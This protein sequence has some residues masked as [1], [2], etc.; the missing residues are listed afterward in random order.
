MIYKNV[1]L[2]CDKKANFLLKKASCEDFFQTKFWLDSYYF[3][4]SQC[5]ISEPYDNPFWENS[6]DGRERNIVLP[7]LPRWLHA[8]RTSDAL[9][10]CKL[11]QIP[12]VLVLSLK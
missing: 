7:K 3:C 1:V 2:K 12:F 8:L 5:K 11:K 9:I 4:R 6:Y 10:G